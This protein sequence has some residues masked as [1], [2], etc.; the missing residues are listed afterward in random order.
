VW[1]KLGPR[2]LVVCLLL[3]FGVPT[4]GAQEKAKGHES[5]RSMRNNA[6]HSQTER[7]DWLRKLINSLRSAPVANPPAEIVT[8]QYKGQRVYYLPPRCCDIPSRLFDERGE[9][10]CMP[11]G[12]RTGRG[13]GR[14]GDFFTERKDEQ[15]VWKDERN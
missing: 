8:Y 4:L 2:F 15:L 12:G 11:D 10:M 1:G 13:D 5:P 3:T 14:C 6:A 9:E 7:P